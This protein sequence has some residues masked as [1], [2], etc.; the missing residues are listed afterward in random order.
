[1]AGHEDSWAFRGLLVASFPDFWEDAKR[2]SLLEGPLEQ[3]EKGIL[4][5]IPSGVPMKYPLVVHRVPNLVIS[6]VVWVW[7]RKARESGCGGC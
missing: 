3:P 7:I 1:M 6:L 2:G 4:K 5:G